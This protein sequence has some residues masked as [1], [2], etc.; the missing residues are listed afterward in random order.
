MVKDGSFLVIKLFINKEK[1]A[2]YKSLTCKIRKPAKLYWMLN[3]PAGPEIDFDFGEKPKTPRRRERNLTNST[4]CNYLHPRRQRHFQ[5]LAYYLSFHL[6]TPDCLHRNRLSGK[7]CMTT[8]KTAAQRDC[9]QERL[10]VPGCAQP[11]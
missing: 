1:H 4:G 2:S 8:E 9:A 11:R 3:R 10:I 7:R 6:L 5:S